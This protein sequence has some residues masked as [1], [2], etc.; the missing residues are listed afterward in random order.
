MAKLKTINIKGKDYVQVNERIRFFTENYKKG[1]ITTDVTFDG[2]YVRVRATVYP[3]MIEEPTRYFTGHAEEDRTQGNINKTNALE[4]A[5]TSAIGRALGI[6]GIGILDS[7]ATAEEVS[8]AIYKQS[9]H[10]QVATDWNGKWQDYV[11]PFTKHKGEKL[12]EVPE[13]FLSWLRDARKKEGG[14]PEP[15]LDKALADWD[16]QRISGQQNILSGEPPF[17]ANGASSFFDTQN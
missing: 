14:T 17:E 3:N 11:L 2:N 7:V 13:S 8:H 6:M 10:K 4:N 9:T 15:D 5:E 1:A 12:S 16:K